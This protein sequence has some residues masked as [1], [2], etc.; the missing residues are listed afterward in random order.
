MREV[1]LSP[2]FWDP[3]VYFARYSWPVEFV[4]RALKDIGW[5]G[6]SVN[7]ALTPLSN[8]G[9]NL[10]DPPDVAGWDLGQSWFSTGSMLARMNFAS[11]LAGEPEVQPGHR[12]QAPYAKTPECAALVRARVDADRAARS[13]GRRRAARRTCARPAR[14]PAA[15]RSCRRRCRASCTSS[16]A[17]RSTSSYEGHE[18]AVRQGR[19]RG[20]HG[21]V[22]RARSS[23]RDLARAQGAHVR[24]LVVLYLSGG[25][26]SLSM[27]VPYN[28]PFYYSRRP[29]LAVPAA[30]V[31]QIGTDRRTSRSACIRG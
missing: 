8:M 1:L 16:R 24:N 29:T 12:R 10:Y 3:A 28:D 26:D 31:L 11:T 15:T 21:D 22:R 19:R 2:E 23:C 18:T 20:V 14:G 4:V 30:N 27:L 5:S 6:F 7:D 17:R 13:L 9:Q 25:N